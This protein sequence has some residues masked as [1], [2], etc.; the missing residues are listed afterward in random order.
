MF[1]ILLNNYP[2]GFIVVDDNG[3]IVGY[4]IYSVAK[5][6][7]IIASIGVLPDYRKKG[8]GQILMDNAINNLR[9]KV[10]YVELQV[11]VSNV[12]AISLY[13][14]NG[15]VV[16]DTISRYYPDGGDAYLMKRM[17]Y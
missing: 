6:K 14:K 12:V 17:F 8:I 7:G 15:F 13:K 3:K 4:I 1:Y 9:N 10:D 2:D 5:D 16:V 11:S